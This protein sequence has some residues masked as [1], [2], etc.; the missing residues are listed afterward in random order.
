VLD[1][2]AA[3]LHQPLLPCTKGRRRTGC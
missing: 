3:G 1:Q 2:P